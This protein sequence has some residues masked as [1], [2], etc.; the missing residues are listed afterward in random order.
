MLRNILAAIA[1]L[2][3][4]FIVVAVVESMSHIVYPAPPGLDPNDA[5]ALAGY[6]A[7]LPAGA[8]LFVLVAW[9][10]GALTGTFTAARVT[11]PVNRRPALVVTGLFFASCALNLAM[12]PHPTWF[13]VA[14][15]PL[16]AGASYL[17]LALGL[18]RRA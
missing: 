4:A 9:V 1:G 13:V 11:R 6:I 8:F 15:V 5:E 12:I 16:V 18:K 7:S 3:L 14:A 2:A 17:G 10:L